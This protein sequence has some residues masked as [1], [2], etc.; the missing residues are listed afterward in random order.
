MMREARL[1]A[2]LDARLAASPDGV[3]FVDGGREIT[4]AGFD[5]ACRRATARLQAEGIGRGDLVAVWLVNRVEWL[6]LL[7][8]L[9]RL[10]AALVTINTR[11]RG[12][13]VAYILRR[14]RARILVTQANFRGIDFLAILGTVEPAALPALEKI[15]VLDAGAD[16]LCALG[17]P[18]V[19]LDFTSHLPAPGEDA[20]DPDASAILFSTS[21]TTK[22]PKLVVH[23]QRTL[24]GH[25]RLCAAAHGLDQNG[26]VLLA[27]LPLCGVFGLNSVLAAFCAGAPVVL[28]DAFDATAAAALFARHRV[29]HMYGAD[30]MYRRLMDVVPGDRPFPSARVFGFGAFTTSFAEDAR[31]AWARGIPFLGLYGS[32]EVLA[33]FAA[34]S[35]D[36]PVNERVEGGGRP[37]AGAQALVRIRDVETGELAAAGASG[38]IEISA[39]SNFQGYFDDPD[40]T[41]AAVLPDGFFR[42]GDVGHL[43]SDGTFVYETRMGDAIRLGGFLVNPAEIEE[44]LKR[45]P[46]VSDAQVVSVEIEGRLRACAFVIALAGQAVEE[47]G[48]IAYARA[49]MAPFKV[50]AR[51]WFVVDYPVTDGSNGVKTQR[52]RLRAMA[53]ERLADEQAHASAPAG[54]TAI[55]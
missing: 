47:A 21:G 55:G 27:V 39:P 2:L 24:V 14:S 41:A 53:S 46:G 30:D 34:Q 10:G 37:V 20:S 31:I 25:A 17:W 33:L 11:Y 7:F 22:G 13:E 29:T 9:A 43:R 18:S 3:A 32:S 16:Q 28:M 48:L 5:E 52:N 38:E 54:S 44:V 26:A 19:G 35:A 45:P 15:A 23:P 40:A 51:I 50:P 8:A 6:A 1:S 49:A 12:E 42:T 4:V 36:L